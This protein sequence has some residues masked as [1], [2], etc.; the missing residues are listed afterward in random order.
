MLVYWLQS[1]QMFPHPNA[2]RSLI[3]IPDT[4]RNYNFVSYPRDKEEEKRK[5]HSKMFEPKT[6]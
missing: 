1:A 2:S 5:E 6:F 3:D 4:E